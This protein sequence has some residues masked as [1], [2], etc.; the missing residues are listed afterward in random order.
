MALSEIS[1]KRRK[2]DRFYAESWDLG[3]VSKY[4]NRRGFEVLDI[5][6]QWRHVTAKIARDQQIL[7]FKLGSTPGTS[8][9]TRNETRWNEQVAT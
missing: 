7:F 4:L 9:A 3:Y 6:Q 2:L 8:R 1:K 5:H